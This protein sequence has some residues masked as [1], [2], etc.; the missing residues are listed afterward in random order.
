MNKYKN[1]LEEHF[2]NFQILRNLAELI[3]T[4]DQFLKLIKPVGH[5]S[6]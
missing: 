3:F 4:H 1:E 2:I 5:S 6:K